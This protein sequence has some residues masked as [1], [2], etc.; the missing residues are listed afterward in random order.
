MN[1]AQTNGV[2]D[3][4]NEFVSSLK[5][6]AIG[7]SNNADVDGDSDTV[8]DT[9]LASFIQLKE[10]LQSGSFPSLPAYSKR[11]REIVT[12]IDQE[13]SESR[14]AIGELKAKHGGSFIDRA[15]L[16]EIIDSLA[17]FD[18]DHFKN[19]VLLSELYP[20]SFSLQ[21]EFIS[22]WSAIAPE[23]TQL[24]R[25]TST[26][27][28]S[29]DDID[30]IDEEFVE[31]EGCPEDTDFNRWSHHCSVSTC[32]DEVLKRSMADDNTVSFVF[33]LEVNWSLLVAKQEEIREEVEQRKLKMQAELAELNRKRQQQKIKLTQ[34]ETNED[35]MVDDDDIDAIMKTNID[36]PKKTKGK[37]N[38]KLSIENKEN[39]S[40]SRK[41]KSKIKKV[42]LSEDE[43]EEDFIE[44]GKNENTID[45]LIVEKDIFS[46]DEE[47]VVMSGEARLATDEDSKINAS[48]KRKRIVLDENEGED[49]EEDD[50]FVTSFDAS[51]YSSKHVDSLVHARQ[52]ID[53]TDRLDNSQKSSDIVDLVNSVKKPRSKRIIDSQESDLVV[54]TNCSNLSEPSSSSA[55]TNSTDKSWS[56][57]TCTFMNRMKA[58][59]CE[60]CE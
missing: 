56:C 10:Q 35:E 38:K 50:D 8:L 42:V 5:E 29:V 39:I 44:V 9:V 18:R 33:G 24:S 41:K 11:Q 36:E 12:A 22:K 47:F 53:S 27:A 1:E 26:K 46:S 57:V 32:D 21:A 2:I 43:S 15:K 59:V 49:I 14:V 37:K 31:Q 60:M 52:K 6:M 23:L 20:I 34:A 51:K 13:L 16:T 7:G 45:K 19:A 40:S 30:E 4:L 25:V 3:F 17:E 48:S 54:L 28:N 58:K 55:N